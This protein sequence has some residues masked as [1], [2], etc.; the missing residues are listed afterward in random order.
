[1]PRRRMSFLD[2]LT[3]RLPPL[4]V[5]TVTLGIHAADVADR[6]LHRL[7]DGLYQR[8]LQ[9]AQPFVRTCGEVSAEF[10]VPILQR[11]VCVA[12]IDLL[13]DGH[14]P[15]DV[16]NLGRTLDGAAAHV[17]LDQIAGYLVRVQH[18]MSTT[19]RQMIAAFPAVLSQTE[20]VQA[21]V[22]AANS[23]SGV[24]L[25]AVELLGHKV[26]EA[27]EATADRGG[28]R[29]RRAVDPRPTCQPKVRQCRACCHPRAGVTSRACQCQ[30]DGID[31]A[32]AGTTARAGSAS[33]VDDISGRYQSR[34][35]SIGA[36]SRNSS[37]G[38]PSR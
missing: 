17:H 13:C 35:V 15:D 38:V 7:C 37:A 1:M 8:V 30:R 20:R 11:R 29:C 2:P 31:P 24:N 18:G 27:A 3:T 25:D 12:P 4:E 28:V 23:S 26:K 33:F 36:R 19:S 22:V 9:R 14:S 21:A 16:V 5:R 6:S 34:S 10:G 32:H